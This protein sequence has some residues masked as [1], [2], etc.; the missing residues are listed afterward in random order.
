MADETSDHFEELNSLRAEV[1]KLR[2]EVEEWKKK[3]DQSKATVRVLATVIGKIVI[4][5]GCD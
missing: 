4:E 3:A 2:A 1:V 5:D